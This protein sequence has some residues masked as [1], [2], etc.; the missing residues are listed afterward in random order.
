MKDISLAPTSEYKEIRDL[1]EAGFTYEQVLAI[2]QL[3]C[4]LMNRNF[5]KL[6]DKDD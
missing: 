2:G 4:A 5:T 1:Y 3:I 6:G